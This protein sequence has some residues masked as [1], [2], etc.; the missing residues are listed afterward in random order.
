MS[1]IWLLLLLLPLFIWYWLGCIHFL[2]SHKTCE[3]FFGFTQFHVAFY[4]IQNVGF[5]QI[6]TVSAQI[7]GHSWLERHASTLF[8]K[9]CQFLRFY[10]VK[11]TKKTSKILYNTGVLFTRVRNAKRPQ[12]L[13]LFFNHSSGRHFRECLLGFGRPKKRHFLK[14]G[15]SVLLSFIRYVFFLLINKYIIILRLVN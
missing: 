1:I 11:F 5:H 3:C 10:L 4:W 6:N 14:Q 8:S 9:I 7:K 13:F 12:F 2:Q 15:K